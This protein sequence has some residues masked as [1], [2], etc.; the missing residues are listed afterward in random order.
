MTYE[1]HT[2]I[3]DDI[4]SGSIW[5]SAPALTSRTI[6]HVRNT[7]NNQSLRC[8]VKMVDAYYLKRF[9]EQTGRT[10]DETSPQVFINAWYRKA[11]GVTA[12]EGPI[13]L[14]I[15][16]DDS[17]RGKVRACLQHPQVVV[18]I[19][20]ILGLWSVALGVIGLALGILSLVR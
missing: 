16:A 3:W 12:R 19:A 8:E 20:T 4:E 11:L 17:L 5:I 18:R 9:S 6:V 10:V 2:A 14:E 1:L 15:V 13:E 7:L